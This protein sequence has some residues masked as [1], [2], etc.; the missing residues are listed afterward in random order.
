MA[1]ITASDATPVAA[2]DAINLTVAEAPANTSVGY[3][4]AVY[5]HSPAILYASDQ[6][7]ESGA[8]PSARSMIWESIFCA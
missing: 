4:T 2:I 3:S 8:R 1:T 6:P 7:I 5:P